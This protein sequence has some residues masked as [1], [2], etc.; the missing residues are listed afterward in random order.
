MTDNRDQCLSMIFSCAQ[1]FIVCNYNIAVHSFFLCEVMS[2]L[3]YRFITPPSVT[4]VK[5]FQ[6]SISN[7]FGKML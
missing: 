3:V 5:L 7:G 1:V 2:S 4:V 6:F